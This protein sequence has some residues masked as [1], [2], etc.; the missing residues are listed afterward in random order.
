MS[1]LPCYVT[2]SWDDGHPCDLRIAGALA[3]LDIPGTF[4]IPA[5]SQHACMDGRHMRELAQHFEVGAHTLRHLRLDRLS[6]PEANRE[7]VGSRDYIEQTLGKSCSLFAP[8]AGRFRA[9]HLRMAREAG[10]RALRT[11]ELMSLAPPRRRGGLAVMPTTLQVFRHA[12]AAYWRNSLRRLRPLN[13]WRYLRHGRAGTSRLHSSRCWLSPSR[14]AESC[15]CG[16]MD[17]KSKSAAIGL[18]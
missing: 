11:T 9:A 12:G 7:I 5:A 17:G 13:L 1:A 6:D 15:T 3:R 14:G 16:D 18:Y 8:P 10:F 4:Y 2:S